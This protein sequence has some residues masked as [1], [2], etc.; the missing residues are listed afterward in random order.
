M[1]ECKKSG[2]CWSVKVASRTDASQHGFGLHDDVCLALLSVLNGRLD[3]TMP[4]RLAT[5]NQLSNAIH[6]SSVNNK[7]ESSKYT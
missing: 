4:V 1:H 2:R 3:E 6:V 5:A 7:V